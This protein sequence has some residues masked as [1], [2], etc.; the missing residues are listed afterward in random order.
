MSEELKTVNS[1]MTNEKYV[2]DILYQKTY[3]VDCLNHKFKKNNGERTKY[4]VGN[5]HPAIISRDI[6]NAV[7]LERARR[8]NKAKKS[9]KTIT[10]QGR[11]C[12]KYAF[13]EL[14]ICGDCGSHLKRRIKSNGDERTVYWRCINRTENGKSACPDSKGLKET[15]LQEAVCRC[16]KKVCSGGT[17]GMSIIQYN[18]KYVFCDDSDSLDVFAIE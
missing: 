6:F 11:Y 14:L 17:S 7:Q 15:D 16:F 8:S 2:G 5:N 3:T 10:P 13:S 12:G 18:L 4:L 1:I 9:D